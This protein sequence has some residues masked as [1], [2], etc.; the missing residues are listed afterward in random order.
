MLAE[1]ILFAVIAYRIKRINKLSNKVH[2]RILHYKLRY[3][4]ISYNELIYEKQK[5]RG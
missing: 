5:K 4:I 3:I 2:K 1:D